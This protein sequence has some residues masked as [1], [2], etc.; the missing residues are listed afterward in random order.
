MPRLPITLLG[1]LLAG[2]LFSLPGVARDDHERARQALQAG[3]ILPLGELLRR[4]AQDYPGDV[5]EVELERDKGRWIYELE[6]IRADG[7]L[8]ELEIDASDGSLLSIEGQNLPSP[9]QGKD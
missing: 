7:A 8:I 9:L 3:E 5:I 1:L 2:L 6:I 4:V